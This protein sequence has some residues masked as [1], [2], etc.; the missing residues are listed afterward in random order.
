MTFDI[1]VPF[2]RYMS[3]D[4][5]GHKFFDFL[6]IFEH[7]RTPRVTPGGL[8]YFHLGHTKKIQEKNCSIFFLPQYAQILIKI[9]KVGEF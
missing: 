5:L 7:A 2:F 9:H 3:L 6:C 8:R 1:R 4:S